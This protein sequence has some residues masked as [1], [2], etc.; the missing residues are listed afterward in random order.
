MAGA[1]LPATESGFRNVIAAMSLGREV[2]VRSAQVEVVVNEE[3]SGETVVYDD[4][5]ILERKS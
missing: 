2:F 1:E 5:Q 4:H 3:G